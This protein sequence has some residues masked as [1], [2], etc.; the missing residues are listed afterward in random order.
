MR[1]R[2][3][4]EVEIRL[5]WCDLGLREEAANGVGEQGSRGRGR[6][7]F[8]VESV[9][10]FDEAAEVELGQRGI[11]EKS[12]CGWRAA[13]DVELAVG[14]EGEQ[15]GGG[16]FVEAR[17]EQILGRC[18]IENL[19]EGSQIAREDGAGCGGGSGRERSVEA[20]LGG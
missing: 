20:D 14:T 5:V 8:Q 2:G 9:A 19:A 16:G 13:A 12:Q 10:A 4:G 7:I 6:G 11:V 15:I 1:F 3:G 17:G 18:R